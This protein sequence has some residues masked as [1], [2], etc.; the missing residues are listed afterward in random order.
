MNRSEALIERNTNG[1]NII[2]FLRNNINLCALIVLLIIGTLASDSFLQPGNVL[3]VLKFISINGIVAAGFTV[4][5]LSGGFDLSLGSTVS[6]C[7]CL[8]MGLQKTSGIGA[9]IVFSLLA[10][11][12]FGLFNGTL[13]RITKG[14]LGDTFL[15][16]LGTSLIG[17]SIAYTYSKGYNIYADDSFSPVYRFIGHGEVLGIPMP[18]VIM[19]T[20]MIFLQFLLKKTSFGREIYLIGGN[21]VTSYMSGINVHTY[22]TI[23]FMIAGM[24]AA[25][26]AMILTSRTTAA[27]PRSGFGYDFDAAIAAVIG[28]NRVGGGRGGLAHTF[29]GAVIFGVLTNI[30][31]LLNIN[32]VL[33]MI[34]KGV[35]LVLALLADNLREKN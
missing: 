14:D 24:C 19:A 9:A 12:A 16:T 10:G 33:Q 5:C 35:M 17:Q 6:V 7:A 13:L 15:I 32:P 2:K 26:A 21:K 4:V 22:K 8:F 31:N 18:I 27:S 25:T 34:I 3:N 28:G 29:I 11:A 1:I 30:M 20:I 23:A